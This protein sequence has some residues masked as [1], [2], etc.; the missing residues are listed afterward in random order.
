MS[1]KFNG[2]RAI[3]LQI[4]EHIK[5]DILRGTYPPGSQLPTVRELALEASVNP[6]TMQRAFLEL[7]GSGLVSAQRTAGRYVTEDT[8]LLED[9]RVSMAQKLAADF[10]NQIA[11][12]GFNCSEA[13]ELL[14]EQG[15]RE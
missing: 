10:L 7:E 5:T 12:L 1:W 11:S 3:Y 14:Q 8:S 2:E 6:N 4:A 13:V 9:I 15:G